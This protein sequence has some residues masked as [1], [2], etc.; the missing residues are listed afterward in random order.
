MPFSLHLSVRISEVA[1][2]LQKAM[3]APGDDLAPAALAIARVEY[4][5]LDPK[6]YLAQLDRMGVEARAR[7]RQ[8]GTDAVI[9]LGCLIRGETAHFDVITDEVGRGLGAAARDTGKPVIFGVLTTENE[10]QALERADPERGNKGREAALA[11]LEMA[12][13]HARL[14]GR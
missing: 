4:P 13:L 8:P 7:A 1:A 10:A 14:A 9:A 12:A 11:A 3:N 6:P 2:E 5:S